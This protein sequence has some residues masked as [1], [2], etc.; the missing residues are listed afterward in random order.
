MR[1]L[2]A[3]K[4]PETGLEAMRALGCDLTCDPELNGE[5]LKEALAGENPEVLIVR[6]TRVEEAHL[7]CAPKLGLII[8]A[9]AGFNNIDV[10]AASARGI[11]VANCPGR[12]AVAVAE[13]A[14]AHLLSTD[15]RLVDGALELR[16]GRWNKKEFAKAAG[17]KGKTLGLVGLGNIGSEMIPRAKAFEMN[18]VAWSRSLT[19]EEAERCGVMRASSPEEVAGQCD[20]MSIH[21]ALNDETRGLIDDRVLGALPHGALVINTARAELL[22]QPSLERHLRSGRLR[23]A[24]DVFTGEPSAKTGEID[25]SLFRLPG[26]QGSH[27]IGASTIQ[28]QDAVA[29]ETVR[30]VK[31]MI[32]ES[33]VPNCVNL[34]SRTAA[35][36]V[37]VIR[38]RDRVGV[39]AN[40]LDRLRAARI[41]VQQMENVVFLGGEA[42]VARIELDRDPETETLK[43]IRASE[44]VLAVEVHA[45][46][47]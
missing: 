40:V 18:V 24:L 21:L 36:H 16:K 27:H 31:T 42:A 20:I 26:V 35:S 15:R 14:F 38:H 29:A 12:N 47:N 13:L 28:A 30:I 4:F 22:D 39:L 37:I 44:H 11:Y 10:S 17:I 6:S 33:D 45:L 5:P 25:S 3:D 43:E 46:D 23:A 32:E 9:G 1:I 41:N 8:R 34:A 19:S 2:L 7:D